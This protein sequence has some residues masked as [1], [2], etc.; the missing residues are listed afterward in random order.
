VFDIGLSEFFI[1]G[2]IALVVLGPERLPKVAR[3]V[4]QTIG[5]LQ[6]YVAQVKSDINREMDTAELGKIKAEIENAGRTLK[7]EVEGHAQQVEQS[8]R[9]AGQSVQSAVQNESNSPPAVDTAMGAI[10]QSNEQPNAQSNEQPKSIDQDW[11]QVSQ[12]D[13]GQLPEYS[14]DLNVT[15]TSD[16]HRPINEDR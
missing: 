16:S 14:Q 4:G 9:D 12:F 2:V 10:E 6:R 13:H 15:H 7:S 8:F 3:T 5:K 1:I 11:A